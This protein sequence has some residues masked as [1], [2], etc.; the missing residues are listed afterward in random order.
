MTVVK[1]IEIISEYDGKVILK[2]DK[3]QYE[4]Y[5]RAWRPALPFIGA[6]YSYNLMGE[7]R[8]HRDWDR[9]QFQEKALGKWFDVQYQVV[10]KWGLFFETFQSCSKCGNLTG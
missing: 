3:E 2:E 6:S 10:K 4:E 5:N 9:T 7:R 1:I 8:S